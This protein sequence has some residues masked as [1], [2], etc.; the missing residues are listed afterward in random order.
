MSR[1]TSELPLQIMEEEGRVTVRFPANTA[2]SEANAEELSRRLGELLN[3]V[4]QGQLVV[5]LAEVSL[6]T[7]MILAKFISLNGRVRASGGRLTLLNPQPVVRE[8]FKITRLDTVL[9]V[10][11]LPA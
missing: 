1:T 6:L 4:R 3:R 8:V 9:D 11:K 2:L 5:D 10:A 7:S